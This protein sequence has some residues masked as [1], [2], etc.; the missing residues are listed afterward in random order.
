V[1]SAVHYFLMFWSQVDIRVKQRRSG[2]SL[3]EQKKKPQ[4]VPTP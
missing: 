2:L 4:D 1:A 3:L